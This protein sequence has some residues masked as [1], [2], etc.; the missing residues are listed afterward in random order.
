MLLNSA[1]SRF[2][3]DKA[4]AILAWIGRHPTVIL[5]VPSIYLLLF[6]PIL[7]KDIDALGQLIW[8]AGS[9]NILH[10]PPL[11]CFSGRI[12]FW[13][14]D[15][16]DA[17][18]FG[19]QLP[20]L[21][22][23]SEQ[24]PSIAGL[25]T[26]I[27]TQHLALV[28]ALSIFLRSAAKTALGR[29]LVVL[30]LVSA[31]SLYVQEQC[32]GSESFSVSA[33][34]LMVATGMRAFE[35]GGRRAW[36]AFAVATF[37]VVGTRHIN[38]VLSIWLP[39]TFAGL[40]IGRLLGQRSFAP[41]VMVRVIVSL[42]CAVVAL[43]VNTLIAKSM[44]E[45]LGQEYRST[46]GLTLSDR[47]E[48]FTN[49]LSISEKEALVAK[50]LA[51]ERD[52]L[53]RLAIITQAEKGSLHSG[54]AAAIIQDA[55]AQNSLGHGSLES[56][57]DRVIL[58]E[59]LSYLRSVHPKLVRIILAD[60]G[61]GYLRVDNG[62]LSL[63][64]FLSTRTAARMS[65]ESPQKWEALNQLHVLDYS[66]ANRGVDRAS[67]DLYLALG[68]PIPVIVLV[69]ANIALGIVLTRHGRPECAWLALCLVVTGSILYFVNCVCVYYND[70][71]VLPLFVCNIAALG[72][73]L[74]RF[75]DDRGVSPILSGTGTGTGTGT[76]S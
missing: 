50:L 43:G 6:Y 20:T 38:I 7:W 54:P 67:R 56:A 12:A 2:P 64:R 58:Q 35:P 5:S 11:Y 66:A 4:A 25:Y 70:R 1:F 22:I 55:V 42:L 27:F 59:A 13:I 40:I 16:L 10:Y 71:Y 15:L 8:P 69:V 30:S 21:D 48:A 45:S 74:G 26:L 37:L 62:K 28:F 76:A 52:P 61:H 68:G 44:M 18:F 36:I 39:L 19:K 47:L 73:Q 33:I 57:T 34:I 60:W 31:S 46:L 49:K 3:K 53:V 29:G 32:A 75:I 14:G 51:A 24:R 63:S 65:Q 72:I 9:T 17:A 23:L 41:P